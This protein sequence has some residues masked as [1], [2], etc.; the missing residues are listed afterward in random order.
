MLLDFVVN[1]TSDQHAWF[2]ESESSRTNPKADW[3]VWHDGK[4]PDQRAVPNNW[5]S[6]FGGPAW[7]WGAE[8]PQ[9]YYHFFYKQ[10]PDLNWRNPEVRKA[11]YGVMR[12]W[13]DKGVS[14]FRLD[15]LETLF[16]D[17]KLTDDPVLPGTNAFGDPNV[18]HVHTTDLP[19]MHDVFREMRQVTNHCPGGV[20]VGEVY[21][22]TTKQMEQIYGHGDE[23]NL[24]M[25][26]QVGLPDERSAAKLWGQ[27][28]CRDG[29]AVRGHTAPG[30][31]QPRPFAKLGP[32]W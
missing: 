12:F 14:G 25:A 22:P 31:R 6:L 10:Q 1:H 17:P 24:P 16:E 13:M 18:Q 11:M 28:G 4:G 2:R 29:P 9:F 8:R 32:L 5:T 23:I 3:Y 20:L 19:E 27:T 26:T 21:Y 15:A 7:E 30:V